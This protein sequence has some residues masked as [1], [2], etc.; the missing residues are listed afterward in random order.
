MAKNAEEKKEKYEDWA[1][2]KIT[3]KELADQ[4]DAMVASDLSDRSKFVR[5]LIRQE[6]LRRN[7]GVH[8][9]QAKES[10]P[11]PLKLINPVAVS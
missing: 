5:W 4:L 8:W 9:V 7:Q 1:H 10:E 6:W 2:I 3:D 11:Q